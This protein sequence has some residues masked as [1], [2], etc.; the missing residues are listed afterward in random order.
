M[1]STAKDQRVRP[2]FL[3]IVFGDLRLNF[4]GTITLTRFLGS[5]VLPLLLRGLRMNM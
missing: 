5:T 3:F 4:N 2:S 1:P